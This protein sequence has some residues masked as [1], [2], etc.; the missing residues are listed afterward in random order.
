MTTEKWRDRSLICAALSSVF[1]A[2]GCTC[3]TVQINWP[4]CPSASAAPQSAKA[5]VN[6][7]FGGNFVPVYGPITTSGTGGS[8]CGASVQNKYVDL[9]SPLNNQQPT[10]GNNAFV[11][12]MIKSN[13]TTHATVDIS[14]SDYVLRLTAGASIFVCCE[15]LDPLYVYGTVNPI[16]NYK[17]KAYWITGKTPPGTD[18]VVI[19]YGA[20]DTL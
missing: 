8:V 9:V 19:L 16:Y 2:V 14:N 4:S 18:E 13:K 5:V 3:V 20:W 15:H 6:R 12:H 11:G 10:P 17:F 7:V 1:L